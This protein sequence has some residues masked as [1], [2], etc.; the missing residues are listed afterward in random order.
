MT[1]PPK[2]AAL[3]GFARKSG[4]LLSGEAAVQAGLKKR[5]IWL[6]ILATDLPE[7]RKVH[8][9]RQCETSKIQYAYLGSK[10]EYGA[11]L[12][13]SGRGVLALA[14]RKMALAIQ[15]HLKP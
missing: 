4:M 5:K 6:V 8:W 11:I 2:I 3:L 1:V 9:E 13:I 14:D 7:K 10:D 12:G 15:N